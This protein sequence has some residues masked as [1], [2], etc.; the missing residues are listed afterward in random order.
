MVCTSV[1]TTGR[2]N[3]TADHSVNLSTSDSQRDDGKVM[4]SEKSVFRLHQE[5]LHKTPAPHRG[6]KG[7]AVFL[8]MAGATEMLPLLQCHLLVQRFALHV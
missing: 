8:F 1:M 3:A 2:K 5:R 4:E 6:T 7:L